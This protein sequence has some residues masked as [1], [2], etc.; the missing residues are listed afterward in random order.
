MR[1][2]ISGLSFEP[3]AWTRAP[4]QTVERVVLAVHYAAGAAYVLAALLSVSK[5]LRE[6]DDALPARP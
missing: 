2:R 4:T 3:R 5:R 1:L 6:D